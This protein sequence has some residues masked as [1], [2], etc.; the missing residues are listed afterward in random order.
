MKGYRV[1]G[2]AKNGKE[3]IEMFKSFSDKP[4]LIVMDHRMPVKDGLEASKEILK[5]DKNLKIIFVSADNTVK[6]EALSMGVVNFTDKPCSVQTLF[7]S[8]ENALNS[9]QVYI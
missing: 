8:I 5:I 2:S 4:D 9:P 6:E 1:I 3:A 7:Q